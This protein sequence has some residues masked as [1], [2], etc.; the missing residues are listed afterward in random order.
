MSNKPTLETRIRKEPINWKDELIIQSDAIVSKTLVDQKTGTI[1][2]FAFDQGQAL[3]EHTAPFDAFVHILSGKMKI[4]L[5]G[6]AHSLN[7]GESLIMPTDIPHALEAVEPAKM[8][9][10]MIRP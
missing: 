7:A 2:V 9:L 1:T 3:S 6:T 5:D 4:I 8:L 10:V